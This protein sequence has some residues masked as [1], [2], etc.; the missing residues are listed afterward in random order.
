MNLKNKKLLIEHWT[1]LDYKNNVAKSDNEK[2]LRQASVLDNKIKKGKAT[3]DDVNKA[4]L[5]NE[6]FT[7]RKLKKAANTKLDPEWRKNSTPKIFKSSKISEPIGDGLEWRIAT[8]ECNFAL[9]YKLN[10]YRTITRSSDNIDEHMDRHRLI[11]KWFKLPN[12]ATIGEI[13]IEPKI[14]VLSDPSKAT[15]EQLNT[16]YKVEL[17]V[18]YN[19]E[20]NKGKNLPNKLYHYSPV[21]NITKLQPSPR[22]KDGPM[23]SE[24]RIYFTNSPMGVTASRPGSMNRY[25]VDPKDLKGKEVNRDPEEPI[26]LRTL[27]IKDGYITSRDGINVKQQS[28]DGKTHNSKPKKPVEKKTAKSVLDNFYA[29]LGV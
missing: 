23:Y 1:E 3:T 24:P 12:D 10:Y 14:N 11:R 28:K 4:G 17:Q 6:L 19:D 13:K 22:A 15:E 8:I 29:N 2:K 5:S 21:K 27:G 18:C 16:R 9:A 7:S 25:E 20:K 26:A